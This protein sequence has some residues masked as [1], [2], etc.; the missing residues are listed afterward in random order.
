MKYLSQL[1]NNR[2][3]FFL[4]VYYFFFFAAAASLFP[5]IVLFYEQLGLSG[6]QIGVLA[7]IPPLTGLFAASFWGGVADATQ[8][9]HRLLNMAIFNSQSKPACLS[10]ASNS[11]TRASAFSARASAC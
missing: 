2:P 8:Q 1:S 4:K 11:W 3:L 6:R 5:F 10:L 7:A 9:H